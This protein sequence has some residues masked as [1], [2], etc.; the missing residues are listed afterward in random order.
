MKIVIA[1]F[2]ANVVAW[3]G[4][5]VTSQE[6][7]KRLGEG[8]S[9][10]NLKYNFERAYLEAPISTYCPSASKAFF[11]VHI[12]KEGDVRSVRGHLVGLSA[13]LKSVALKWAG[14]LLKQMHFKPL[15]YGT[16]PSSVDMAV[17]LVCTDGLDQAQG[18][19]GPATHP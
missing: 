18:P 14:G 10:Y 1:F 5:A 8:G 3:G 6:Q 12:G 2:L 7:F 15:M 4:A 11:F 9:P 16:K 13:D 17:T 19:A